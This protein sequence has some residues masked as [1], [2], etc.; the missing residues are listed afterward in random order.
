MEESL[1]NIAGFFG[2]ITDA[3]CSGAFSKARYVGNWMNGNGGFS[4]YGVNFNASSS[5]SIYQDNAPVRPLS[6]ITAFLMKY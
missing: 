1:P 4:Q 5:S 2:W 3:N 6:T